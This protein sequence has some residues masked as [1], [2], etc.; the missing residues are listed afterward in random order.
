MKSLCHLACVLWVCILNLSSFNEERHL[1][2][3]QASFLYIVIGRNTC[4]TA[5]HE[6]CS[7]CRLSNHFIDGGT[8]FTVHMYVKSSCTLQV[9][10]SFICQLCLNTAGKKISFIQVDR[11]IIK[12]GFTFFFLVLPVG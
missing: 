5:L 2:N 3:T 12:K 9:P 11:R 4:V 1:P 10:Y 6:A 7:D 8:A